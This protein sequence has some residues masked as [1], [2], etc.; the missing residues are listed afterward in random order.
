MV[1][2]FVEVIGK[3]RGFEAEHVLGVLIA[4]EFVDFLFL[5]PLATFLQNRVPAPLVT[6]IGPAIQAVLAILVTSATA[7]QIWTPAAAVFV[8]VQIFTHTFFRPSVS[9]GP[10][11]TRG[12]GNACDA[13]DWCRSRS[14]R[15]RCS[16]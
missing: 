2:S 14:D 4:F 13:D 6:Q 8:A 1:F 3:S 10:D 11:G 15:R 7:F 5:A 9:V 12:G 16:R